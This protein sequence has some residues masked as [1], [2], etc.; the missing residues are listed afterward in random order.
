MK[1][2]N[3]ELINIFHKRILKETTL[4]DLTIDNIIQVLRAVDSK[5]NPPMNFEGIHGGSGYSNE[6]YATGNGPVARRIRENFEVLFSSG[7]INA[8][9]RSDF[10]EEFKYFFDYAFVDQT[11]YPIVNKALGLSEKKQLLRCFSRWWQNNHSQSIKKQYQFKIDTTFGRIYPRESI[12]V[13]VMVGDQLV[14]SLEHEGEYR[15]I[16]VENKQPQI[17]N[18]VHELVFEFIKYETGY[19]FTADYK[20]PIQDYKNKI[21]ELIGK[22]DWSLC[23]SGISNINNSKVQLLIDIQGNDNPYVTCIVSNPS[24]YQPEEVYTLSFIIKQP[25]QEPELVVSSLSAPSYIPEQFVSFMTFVRHKEFHLYLQN[26]LAE[27]QKIEEK[28]EDA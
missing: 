7:V 26:L 2:L 22:V 27:Q 8:A 9:L 11:E 6:E 1:F 24:R 15:V 3:K 13:A 12:V 17:E 19:D 5:T 23:R 21:I 25:T 20:E 14:T 18:K 10:E 28:N 16:T 4:Q